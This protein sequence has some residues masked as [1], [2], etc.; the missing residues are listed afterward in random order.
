MQADQLIAHH[1]LK[2][3]PE[4]GWYRE[5]YRSPL[6]V[7]RVDGCKRSA[8][9]V[10]LFLLQAGEVSRWHQVRG[11]DETW[12]FAGGA[13]LELITVASEHALMRR[14]L[15]AGPEAAEATPVAVVPAGFWQAARST[16]AWTLV[17]CCVGPGFDFADFGLLSDLPQQ[18]RPQAATP[19]FL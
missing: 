5:L 13:P 19:E 4:G 3:H 10:I 12:H 17:S 18:Q 11:A 8:L 2:P 16:G 7:G 6:P 9:T 14:Q 1:G 15:L